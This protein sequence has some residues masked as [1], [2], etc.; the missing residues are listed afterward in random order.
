MGDCLADH[1]LGF[2]VSKTGSIWKINEVL[3]N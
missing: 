1:V 3:G 2:Q